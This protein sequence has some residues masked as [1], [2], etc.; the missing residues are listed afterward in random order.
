MPSQIDGVLLKS[1]IINAANNLSNYK[2]T[3][4]DMNVFP[5]PDGDTGT[6]MS[7]TIS[8]AAREVMSQ[9]GSNLSKVADSVASASLRGARGNSG[10]ILSQLFRGFAKGVAGQSKADINAFA[11]AVKTASDTAYKAVMKPTEGTMLTVA[12][13]TAEYAVSSVGEFD[14][15]TTFVE[16]LLDVAKRTLDK[17]PDMLPVL[18]QAGVVDAGGMG[19]VVIIEG[20]VAALKGQEIDVLETAQQ[21]PP[22]AVVEHADPDKIKFIYCTEF[23]ITKKSLN[24]SV[25]SFRA[26][27]ERIGDSMLVIED[28]EI[29]KVHVHTN[30]PGHVIE[31]ATKIGELSDIKIDNMKKQHNETIR[32]AP[33]KKSG[34]IAV[35]S[36]EGFEQIFIDI[37]ADS[38]VKGGQSM[39]PSTEDILSSIETVNAEN[40]FVLPNNKNIILA[41]Q[42]AADISD[43]NVIVIPSKTI[44]QGIGALLMFEE[45]ADAEHNK[46]EM[47]QALSGIKTGQVT[48][49]VRASS[50][51]G[52][53]I[54]QGDII[55]LSENDISIIGNEPNEVAMQIIQTLADDDCVVITIFFGNDITE[56]AA[57]QL[58]EN[59]RRLYPNCDVLLHSGGQPI[60][61]YIVSVE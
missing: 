24:Y 9:N 30:R 55:G 53:E 41:A 60:Y 39:N 49:A 31:Q 51:N 42:Q 16:S 29:V 32:T 21:A 12:R 33:P 28:G 38:I 36:G 52:L 27:L 57:N 25:Q 45:N 50:V 26:G 20:F 47:T 46:T 11:N 56:D 54:K 10:V 34:I 23:I 2:K 18:K 3:V 17:T 4:D 40:I 61:H 7:M 19:V 8:A 15:I 37:G 6:N 22:S 14:D 59:I 44:P 13:E 43:K 1:A 35:A 58:A 48:N 5:V